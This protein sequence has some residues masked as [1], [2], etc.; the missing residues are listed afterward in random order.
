[1]N[2]NKA[3][4]VVGAV[5][6]MI[7]GRTFERT[8]RVLGKGYTAALRKLKPG[9]EVFLAGAQ[10]A[11]QLAL[12]VFGKGNYRTHRTPEGTYVAYT[13]HM[14]VEH[15]PT[16]GAVKALS[17]SLARSGGVRGVGND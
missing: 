16:C 1:M 2:Q 6:G 14:D 4:G 7:G 5:R 3:R 8:N 12:L 13:P 11:T 9:E 17:S 15:C 10:N